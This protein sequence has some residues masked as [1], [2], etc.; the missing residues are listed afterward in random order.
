MSE[1]NRSCVWK[2]LKVLVLLAQRIP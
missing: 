2:H 1:A